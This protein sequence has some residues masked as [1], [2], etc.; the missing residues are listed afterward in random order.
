MGMAA[1]ILFACAAIAFGINALN[2]AQGFSDGNTLTIYNWE[3][4]KSRPRAAQLESLVSLRGLG[5]REALAKLALV[6]EAPAKT[7]VRR[8]PK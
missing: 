7:G 8:K 1:V 3:S 4:G 2:T 5:K 6:E